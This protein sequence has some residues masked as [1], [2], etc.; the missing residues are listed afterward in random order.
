MSLKRGN[1]CRDRGLFDKAVVEYKKIGVDSPLYNQ[2]QI[3]IKRIA[4]IKDN[5]GKRPI[6]NEPDSDNPNLP[7][8][9]II[10]P[11]F[12]VGPYLDAS[13]ISAISQNY[14]NFELII[15]NDAST[16][17]CSD[18]IGMHAAQDPRI[19]VVNLTH[20]SLGGAGIPSNIGIRIASGEYIAFIDSDDWV[21]P[22][23]FSVL[24]GY[25]LR[26]NAEVV[27]G[28]FST[29]TDEDRVVSEAYDALAWSDI[30]KERVISVEN[31]PNLLRISP[32]PWRKIY[33]TSFLR[34]HAIEYPE[35]DY[36][37]EDNPLHWFVISK[38]NR[39]VAVDK[40]VSYH[41][42]A[43][44]GQTMGSANFRLAA[45]LCHMNTIYN[46]VKTADESRKDI[47]FPELYDYLY[48]SDW[49]IQRQGDESSA[50][51][52]KKRW[53]AIAD[54][55][56]K[57]YPLVTSRSSFQER[58]ENYRLAYD[59]IDLTIIIPSYNSGD[60]IEETLVSLL[61][62]KKINFNIIVNDDGSSDNTLDVLEYY[63]NINKNIHVFSQKNRGA[64]R[65]RNA[66]IPMATGSYT[67]FMDADDVA[68]AC[69]LEEA[70]I[71]AQKN[72]HDLLF[73]RYKIDEYDENK[74]RGMYNSDEDIWASLIKAG[75][76]E[77]RRKLAAKLINY[78][79]NRVIK[80]Q[81]L[82]DD[83]IFFGPTFVHNDVPYHWHS[84]AAAENIGFLDQAVCTHRKFNSRSQITNTKDARRMAVLEALRYTQDILEHH[85]TGSVLATAWKSFAK[86]LLKWAGERIPE[87]LKQEYL[88]ES[89]RFAE[90]LK[91]FPRK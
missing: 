8:L 75:N 74:S 72:D 29:F 51:L 23:A 44:E 34:E 86:N 81:L 49:V 64:G 13:I 54:H 33:K 3:N 35:G 18:I 12:N 71:K 40:K 58:I 37:F 16:D 27:V 32:V 76:N 90:D 5:E 22:D 65:A 21:L 87:E 57:D 10:M 48:R 78:P 19:K 36:F 9:S 38:A 4:Q 73:F 69:A 46:F 50:P 56:M 61:K 20:N 47:I 77:D 88:S 82:H 43:R 55:M 85:R 89:A 1:E 45:M 28:G 15:I 70:V 25:A 84:I 91:R 14:Q 6:L 66:I 26:E 41:R 60:M 30:P 62:I 68:E 24:M 59:D 53:S 42:M 79:W 80:T 11:V 17:N 63:E 67:F 2:A 39:V 83:N 7:L 31:C 52:M